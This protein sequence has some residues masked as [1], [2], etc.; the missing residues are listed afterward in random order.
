MKSVLIV[1]VLSFFVIF[2]GTFWF[3]GVFEGMG[4]PDEE[5]SAEDEAAELSVV[6]LGMN[7]RS[8]SLEAR[9]GDVLE[10]EN[11]VEVEKA[12]LAEEYNKLEGLRKKLEA[13][14][15]QVEEAQ[16]KSVKKLAK[17]YEAMPAKEAASILSGMDL[18]IVLSVLRQ[19]KDRQAAKIMAALDPS[20]AAALSGMMSSGA[21]TR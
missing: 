4:Q 1:S 16:Q 20:R 5:S 2:A 10:M 15:G 7:E 17:M 11:D 21:A 9:E 3:M 12:V 8:Q 18:E 13:S 6:E 19:M 14:V